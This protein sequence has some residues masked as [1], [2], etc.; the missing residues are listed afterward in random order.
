[1]PFN[2]SLLFLILKL[3]IFFYTSDFQTQAKSS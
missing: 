3:S 2:I 1:M